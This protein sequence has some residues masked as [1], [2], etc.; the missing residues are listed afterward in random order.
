MSNRKI[1]YLALFS[2]VALVLYVF[3]TVIPKPLPWLRF[4]LANL[5]TLIALYDFGWREALWITLIRIVVGSTIVG[6]LLT[7]AFILSLGGGIVALFFMAIC[8]HFFGNQFSIVG[9]SIIGAV[10]N[11]FSQLTIA[12]LVYVRSW[13]LLYLVPIF[14]LTSLIMGSLIGVIAYWFQKRFFEK[15]PKKL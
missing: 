1:V 13:E 11:N 5:I 10:A 9:I 3:E 14:S 12:S 4:G 8:H 6:T 7:P 2:A 15:F